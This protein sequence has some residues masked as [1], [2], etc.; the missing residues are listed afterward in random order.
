M[1]FV[2]LV[3]AACS[4]P[5][6][7]GPYH[8]WFN[9]NGERVRD[10]VPDVCASGEVSALPAVIPPLSAP[11]GVAEGYSFATID[12]RAEAIV[13]RDQGDEPVIDLCIPIAVHA[14]IN[15]GGTNA[16]ITTLDRGVV[17]TPWDALRNTP[18]SA[19]GL[20]AWKSTLPAAPVVNIDWSAKYEAE[21]D[22]I[23]HTGTVVGLVCTVLMNGQPLA[24]TISIDIHRAAAQ[25]PGAQAGTGVT[26]PF[27][28][29]RPP[30]FTPRAAL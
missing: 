9:P 28:Q 19:T 20:V 15:V 8:E 11:P 29:C 18:Y 24:R 7:D 4:V 3:A 5:K 30:A 25:L 14:Y 1:V 27:V 2:S 23:D 16:P 13:M 26:G 22:R 12:L 21:L 6:A 10:Q 17:M